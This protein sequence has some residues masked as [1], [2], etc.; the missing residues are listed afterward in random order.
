MSRQTN[1]LAAYDGVAER[2]ASKFWNELDSKHFDRVM[3][4]WYA[5]Q[6]PPDATVL[7]LGAGP[8]EVSGYLAKLGVRCVGTDISSAMVERAR[9]IFADAEF[10]VQ[11]FFALSYP[12]E[13]FYAAVAYYAIV[14][15]PLVELE[16]AFRQVYRVLERG[17]PFLFTFHVFTGEE[18][19]TVRRF[20][21]TDVA[22]IA[23]YYFRI[24]AMRA[25][26]E[27]IGLQVIDILERQ[28]YPEVEYASKRAYF[29]L[30]KP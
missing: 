30:R 18:Q 25:L 28:P 17:G 27:R 11:D 21:D 23:F 19:T 9:E 2:Y 16:P 6:I 13:S 26:V 5:S 22:E 24:D 3:L 20:L 12:D 29:L 8:G 10:E 15:Y 7:E 1:I 4:G 14:N